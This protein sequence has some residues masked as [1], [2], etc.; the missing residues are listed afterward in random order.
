[1]EE[2]NEEPSNGLKTYAVRPLFQEGLE[3]RGP[4]LARVLARFSSDLRKMLKKESTEYDQRGIMDWGCAPDYQEDIIELALDLKRKSLHRSFLVIWYDQGPSRLAYIPE[5]SLTFEYRRG[6]S[7]RTRSIDALSEEFRRRSQLEHSIPWAAPSGTRIHSWTSTIEIHVDINVPPKE[8][9]DHD[10][11]SILGME[12][13]MS[14]D[15]ELENVGHCLTELYP[16]GLNRTF[17]RDREVIRLLNL[18]Q[19]GSNRPVVIIGKTLSGKTALVHEVAWRLADI[20]RKGARESERLWLI[21]PQR[22]ISG[23]SYVGQWESRLM[24]ILKESRKRRHILYFDDLPG[25]FSAGQTADSGLSVADVMRHS[26]E[27]R[28]IRVVGEISPEAWRKLRERDRRFADLFEVV[29]LDPTNEE[30]TVSIV[31]GVQREL[32]FRNSCEFNPYAVPM[33][34][35]LLKQYASDAA[36]PGKAVRFMDQL[37][38]KNRGREIG[39]SEILEHF[40]SQT[41]L[42][43]EMLDMRIALERSVVEQR[44][45]GMIAGQEKAVQA[46]VDTVLMVKARL[47]DPSR[48]VASMLFLGPTGV[49]KTESA[50]ALARVLFQNEDRLIRFDMNEFLDSGSAQRMVGTPFRDEGLLSRKV[51]QQPFSVILFDEIEKAAPEIFDLLLAV[52]GEGRLTDSMGRTVSFANT[53]VIMTSNLGVKQAHSRVGYGSDGAHEIELSYLSSARQFFKPE[54]FN[55][56]D[57]VIPF[58]SLSIGESERVARIHLNQLSQRFGIQERR[59]LV[60]FQ[61]GAMDLLIRRG[62]HPQYGGRA[63]KRV[64]E[65]DLAGS[66]S[67]QLAIHPANEPLYLLVDAEGEIFRIHSQPLAYASENLAVRKFVD[68]QKIRGIAGWGRWIVANCRDPLQALAPKDLLLTHQNSPEQVDYLMILEQSH[69]VVEGLNA[70]MEQIDQETT[71]DTRPV[72]LPNISARAEKDYRSSGAAAHKIAQARERFSQSIGDLSSPDKREMRDRDLEFWVMESSFLHHLLH[73]YVRQR[74]QLRVSWNFPSNESPANFHQFLQVWMSAMG[75]LVRF[76]KVPV[77]ESQ[78]EVKVGPNQGIHLFSLDGPGSQM[79]AAL[80]CGY[81]MIERSTG[82]IGLVTLSQDVDKPYG[83]I[84]GNVL[85]HI[86]DGL[87]GV[88]LRTGMDITATTAAIHVRQMILSQIPIPTSG[89]EQDDVD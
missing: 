53:V 45:T 4:V 79:I 21:S 32:E 86:R 25:L 75:S 27:R 76:E 14:G 1:M 29:H 47:N 77:E 64:I 15:M 70:M 43:L 88:D 37:A 83:E 87:P 18:I 60:S 67:R 41:G 54:F 62:F 82:E 39:V 44:L 55:R 73:S 65:K 28:D 20:R 30:D 23:M 51:R 6:D 68:Q 56:L 35:R 57:F 22:L 50:K 10:I 52:L 31:I 24:A 16:D 61:Q 12:E 2:S 26:M 13:D 34:M 74:C 5:A 33:I 80:E 38:L 36:F 59:C 17:G 7:L 63:L 48:P 3:R 9:P 42:D 46:M 85:R 40:S 71:N 69:K 49:G 84:H 11:F 19:F 78:S 58:R 89:W 66:L 81:W 8:R 72:I